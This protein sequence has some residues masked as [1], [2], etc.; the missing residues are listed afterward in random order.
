MLHEAVKGRHCPAD[1]ICK[2][3]PADTEFR[4]VSKP[5]LASSTQLRILMLLADQ[6]QNLVANL[7]LD[8]RKVLNSNAC[9]Q[10]AVAQLILKLL[11]RS[12][13]KACC[14]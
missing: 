1:R 7:K 12:K 9:Q 2:G 8:F 3:K 10:R 4:K 6:K 5:A 13:A 11:A 14:K